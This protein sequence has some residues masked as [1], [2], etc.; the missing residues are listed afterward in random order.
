MNVFFWGGV[1]VVFGWFVLAN[2]K[3]SL[4]VKQLVFVFSC[5]WC[6]FVCVTVY[7]MSYSAFTCLLLIQIKEQKNDDCMFLFKFISISIFS[8]MKCGDIFV[9]IVG[10]S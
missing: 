6:V 3:V 2:M 1:E 4:L 9:L 7:C 8:N 10:I 5:T